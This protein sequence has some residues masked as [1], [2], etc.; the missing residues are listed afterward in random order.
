MHDSSIASQRP[1]TELLREKKSTEDVIWSTLYCPFGFKLNA[2][3]DA[4][5]RHTENKGSLCHA[6]HHRVRAQV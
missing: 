2:H 6:T 5:V 4:L 3:I 1:R